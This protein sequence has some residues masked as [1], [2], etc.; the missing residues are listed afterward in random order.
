MALIAH[1]GRRPTIVAG[2]RYQ[3]LAVLPG[4]PLVS[5]SPL[6]SG[7]VEENIMPGCSVFRQTHLRLCAT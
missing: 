5:V 1:R 6:W 7:P 4:L 2:D 3:R